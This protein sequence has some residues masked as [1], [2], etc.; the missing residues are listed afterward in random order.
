MRLITVLIFILS[1]KWCI[2][3]DIDNKNDSSGMIHQSSIERIIQQER[4]KIDS[5]SRLHERNYHDTIL[6]S[7]YWIYDSHGN[8]IGGSKMTATPN[9][10]ITLIDSVTNNYFVLDASQIFIT[11]F[12]EKN[13]KIWKTD[14]YKDNSICEYRTKR[15][16]IIEYRFGKSPDN[17]PNYEKEGIKVIWITYNNTQ[18]GFVDLISG[19]YY[20]LGQD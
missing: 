15:P 5:L 13:K 4:K 7:H 8:V 10:S 20:W 2:A 12:N 3:Q 18:F 19:K 17:F 1:I 14:P 9:E 11:A 16:V 6:T